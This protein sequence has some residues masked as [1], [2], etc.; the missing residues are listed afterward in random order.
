MKNTDGGGW[1]KEL[2]E[3]VRKSCENYDRHENV[4]MGQTWNYHVLPV[5]KN[6]IML[7]E[8]YGGDVLVAEVAALFH[9]FAVTTDTDKYYETHHIMSGELAEPILREYG[10]EQDFIDKVKRVIFAHRASVTKDKFSPEEIA[11]ADADG[12][13]H[14]ENAFEIIVWRGN[15]GE[16]VEQ[17]NAFVKRKIQKTFAK[18]S[19]ETK[20]YIRDRFDA[21][22]KILYSP[23]TE[24]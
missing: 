2:Y 19:A 3:L 7:C 12:V 11:L 13:T 17:A 9:D 1:R 8:R 20:E 23:P 22:M 24:G 15:R 21:V 5:V 6:A 16:T 10:F 4:E 18:L 14:I